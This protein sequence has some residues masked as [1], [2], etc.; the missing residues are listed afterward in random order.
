MRS[1]NSMTISVFVKPEDDED[2]L[3]EALKM[4][5]PFSLE[6]EKI[7]IKRTIATGF[8]ERKIVILEVSLSKE[9]HLRKFM[10]NFNEELSS[11]G[12][13]SLLTQ[14]NRLDDKLMFYIRLDKKSLEDGQLR[15]TDSG[16]CFH[17]KMNIAAFPKKREIGLKVVK[18]IFK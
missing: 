12:K 6:E 11:E 1:L 13:R 2:T 16:D 10:E 7:P 18:E 5:F 4:L 8:N 3:L 14:E 9:R 15:L 17:I